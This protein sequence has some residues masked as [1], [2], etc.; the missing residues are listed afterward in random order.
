MNSTPAL[1]HADVREALR[2]THAAAHAAL[3]SLP[4][5]PPTV[6]AALAQPLSAAVLRLVA[7]GMHRGW[8]PARPRWVDVKALAAGDAHP[9]A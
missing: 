9:D 2:T 5:W 8:T 1:P 4:G 6:H 3:A 7:L